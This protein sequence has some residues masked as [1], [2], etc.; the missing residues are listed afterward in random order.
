MSLVYEIGT[1]YYGIETDGVAISP[2]VEELV[3]AAYRSALNI[4]DDELNIRMAPTKTRCLNEQAQ[5]FARPLAE[6]RR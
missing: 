3:T 2:E 1:G 6:R 4:S 5:T